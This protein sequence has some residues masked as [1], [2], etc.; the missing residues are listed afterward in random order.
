MINLACSNKHTSSLSWRPPSWMQPSR[1]V[2]QGQN[3]GAEFPP[4][5]CWPWWSGCTPGYDCFLGYHCLLPGY[6][7]LFVHQR[8]Q[9]LFSRASLNPFSAQPVFLLGIVPTQVQSLAPGLVN[10]VYTGPPQAWQ[11]PSGWH[12]FPPMCWQACTPWWCWQTCWGCP[13]S[14]CPCLDYVL[15]MHCHQWC[16]V[17]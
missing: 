14:Q 3:R 17:S 2:S 4:L 6:V 13:Q 8:P 7:E 5:A 16:K 9:V 15:Q 11:G 10:E 1:W 12:P